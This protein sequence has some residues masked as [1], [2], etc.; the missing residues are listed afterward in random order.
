MR[1]LVIGSGGR[2]HALA[3]RLAQSAS[4]TEV[5]SAPGSDALRGVGR[6]F[7]VDV[8]DHGAV[9]ALCDQQG[10]SLVVIGPEAPLV[11]GLADS[12][13]ALGLP[14][15]GPGAAAAQLEGSKAYA[16]VLMD[17]CGIPTAAFSVHESLEDALHALRQGQGPIVVKADGLAAGKGV[18]VAPDRVTAE[19]A[20]RACFE[21]RFGQAGA[22]VV[23]EE[24]LEGTELSFIALCDGE[25]ILPLASSQDHKRLGEGDTGP[26]TGGMGAFSPS[27][28]CDDRLK[29]RIV[30]EVMQPVVE[31]MAAEGHPFI[32]FLYAGIMVSPAGDPKVLEFNVRCG[33]PE[34]Q[35]LMHRFRGDFGRWLLAAARGRLST[36]A[37]EADD[38][39]DPQAAVGVVLASH[40]YP[41]GSRKGDAIQGIDEAADAERVTVF[42]AGTRAG[43]QGWET[44]GGRV[45][46]VS[47]LGV[48]L[49]DAATRA[50]GSL[51]GI[52]F[53]GMQW[54][55][56]IGRQ[57]D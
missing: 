46:C 40:S 31:C 49:T 44:N 34:T 25:T 55:G 14:V 52:H 6:C 57:G 53:D 42:H 22:R 28:L 26:N 43:Q 37:H 23:L 32:G 7:G 19:A 51:S 21:G 13:R 38:A 39:W 2:E 11:D 29:A 48:D 45:L 4:V 16:K 8:T 41:L 12:L 47:A 18:T 5:L 50:Y 9:A 30:S 54:R 17:R 20:V 27:P 36:V 56:D 3:W 24:C 33:D 15:V 35:V 1:A 10:V